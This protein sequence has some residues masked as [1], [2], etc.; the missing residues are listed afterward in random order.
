MVVG[1]WLWVVVKVY[2]MV[3][4]YEEVVVVKE[5][6]VM[7]VEEEADEKKREIVVMVVMYGGF[8]VE[9]VVEETDVISC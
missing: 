8:K 2:K 7:T 9:M 1:G 5:V 4:V 3:K 6:E